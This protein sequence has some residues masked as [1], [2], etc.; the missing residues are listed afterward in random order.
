MIKNK[1]ATDVTIYFK[2]IDPTTGKP[3]VGL[4]VTDLDVSYVRD[5][6]AAVKNDVTALSAVDDPHADNK[7]IEVHG[8]NCKG[9][10]RSD[11]PDA[12]FATGVDAVQLCIS[13]DAIDPAYIEIELSDNIAE[14]DYKIDKTTDPDAWRIVF[15]EK[16][17]ANVLMT[18]LI[19][20]VDGNAVKS[21]Y[22]VIG[23]Q[24]EVT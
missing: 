21:A 23:Q 5:R 6:A 13:G 18:K 12:P 2:L 17:T 24:V 19:K 15:Y 20:D 16:G 7:M 11:W 10:Y 14:A 1:G 8:T 9:L 4:T 3:A 22:T